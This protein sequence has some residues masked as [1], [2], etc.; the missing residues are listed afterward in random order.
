[1]EE[2]TQLIELLQQIDT[3]EL[4]PRNVEHPVVREAISLATEYLTNGPDVDDHR[5]HVRQ[6]GY[7]IYPGEVDR[8]GWLTAYIPMKKGILLFG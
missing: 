3:N 2:I 1:M 8:F 6:A 5:Q 4:D 7:P